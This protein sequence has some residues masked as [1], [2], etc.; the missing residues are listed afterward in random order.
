[1]NMNEVICPNCNKA[2]KV[3]ET[4]FAEILK[5]VRD[6]EFEEELRNRL[7]LAEK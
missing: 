2:F 3:D 1:M 6:H 5:Q 4:S 7:L